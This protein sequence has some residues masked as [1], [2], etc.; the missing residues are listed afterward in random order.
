[1]KCTRC[2]REIKYKDIGG[3]TTFDIESI[4]VDHVCIDC[5]EEHKPNDDFTQGIPLMII[6][7]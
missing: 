6:L 1:M 7:S 4:P 2:K 5:C 3:H